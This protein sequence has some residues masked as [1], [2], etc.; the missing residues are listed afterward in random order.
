M[1][2]TNKQNARPID[3][4]YLAVPSSQKTGVFVFVFSGL[5]YYYVLRKVVYLL[6]PVNLKGTYNSLDLTWLKIHTYKHTQ[7]VQV[8]MWMQQSRICILIVLQEK[9]FCVQISFVF[10]C[11]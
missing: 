3:Q 2:K 7:G 4:P 10:Y 9:P 11:F 8:V 1:K 5:T 6:H